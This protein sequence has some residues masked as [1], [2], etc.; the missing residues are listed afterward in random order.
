M[1]C[2][3]CD[4][5]MLIIKLWDGHKLRCERMYCPKC[6]EFNPTSINNL[7]IKGDYYAKI[8]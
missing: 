1:K 6:E 3:V 8:T 2:N 5:P 7:K 4:T